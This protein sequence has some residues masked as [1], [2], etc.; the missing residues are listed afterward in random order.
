MLLEFTERM[1][2]FPCYESVVQRST[3]K[4]KSQGYGKLSI[5]CAADFWNDW[6]YFSH[7][8]FCKA[9]QSSQSSRRDMWRVWIPSRENGATRCD[10][11][12]KFLT[13]AE[14]DQ[15]RSTFG[16]WWPGQPRSSFAA[17]WR[18]NWKAVT[19]R[20]IEQI[21]YGREICEYCWNWTIRHDGRHCRIFT[22]SC[23]GLSWIRSSK[24]SSITTIRMD[25]MEYKDWDRIRSCNLLVT[26]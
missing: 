10:G 5:H 25:P 3:Q 4:K 15:E 17:R 14:R 8:C 7:N 26:G 9:A 1:S 19:R 18:T 24:R 12:N 22:I 16:L 13:R 23:G 20:Q 6:N 21:L 2:N 11:S